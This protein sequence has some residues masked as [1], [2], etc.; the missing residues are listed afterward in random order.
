[1]LPR[2]GRLPWQHADPPRAY[3]GRWEALV[4]LDVAW[5]AVRFRQRGVRLG[6]SVAMP[7]SAAALVLLLQ[8][9]CGA[10]QCGESE[11]KGRVERG[12]QGEPSRDAPQ[13][14]TK[15]DPRVREAMGARDRGLNRLMREDALDAGEVWVMQKVAPFLDDEALSTRIAHWVWAMRREEAPMLALVDPRAPRPSLR[16]E[17][18][19][20]AL[21]LQGYLVASVAEPVSEAAVRIQEFLEEPASKYLLTHQLLVLIWWEEVR[22]FPPPIPG[23]ARERLVARVMEEQMASAEFSDLFA[24]RAFLLGHF[25]GACVEDLAEW[26]RIIRNAQEADGTWGELQWSLEY[27]GREY[28]VSGMTHPAALAIGALQA[29]VNA[30]EDPARSCSRDVG[31][32]R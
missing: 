27:A 30:A 11:P 19:S 17:R 8:A 7:W 32:A 22:G 24:E 6:R 9:A 2:Q 12:P 28:Q 21:R 26:A 29:Y 1:M 10:G 4:V 16:E 25:G 23:D 31:T 14:A 13:G 20:G 5:M 3:R 18:G 15:A